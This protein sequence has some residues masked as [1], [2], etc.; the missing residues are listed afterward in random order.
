MERER[1]VPVPVPIDPYD[2]L[3]RALPAV[4]VRR[5]H[6]PRVQRPRPRPRRRLARPERP[7]A[8]LP[9][10]LLLHRRRAPVNALQR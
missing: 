1:G 5:R 8:A 2:D 3:R 9:P 10:R 7:Q 4:A 6:G